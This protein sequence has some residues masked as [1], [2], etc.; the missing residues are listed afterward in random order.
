MVSKVTAADAGVVLK[1]GIVVVVEA[2]P[3]V[4][5]L[6]PSVTKMHFASPLKTRLD[7]ALAIP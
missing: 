4:L 1:D 3:G 2:V 5:G 7:C 6:L